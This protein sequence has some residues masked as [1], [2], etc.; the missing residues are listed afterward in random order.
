MSI[1]FKALTSKGRFLGFRALV[2]FIDFCES[3][4]YK[5]GFVGNT[6]IQPRLLRQGVV[7]V[8]DAE[9]GERL[10]S[11]SCSV[12]E[13]SSVIHIFVE[14]ESRKTWRKAEL[15]WA[16]LRK[17]EIVFGEPQDAIPMLEFNRRGKQLQREPREQRAYSMSMSEFNRRVKQLQDG[18]RVG[19]VSGHEVLDFLKRL[20]EREGE[21]WWRGYQW[22]QFMDGKSPGASNRKKARTA[23]YRLFDITGTSMEKREQLWRLVRKN[24]KVLEAEIKK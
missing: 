18:T 2:D 9:T 1:Q 24:K 14:S 4:A 3:W 10:L 15:F 5:C 8:S 6:V 17:A 21:E 22:A 13:E 16:S 20:S 19:G 11:M 12:G 23:A 7:F